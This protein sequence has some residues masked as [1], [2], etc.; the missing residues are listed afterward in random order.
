VGTTV[1]LGDGWQITVLSVIPDA[2]N[3]VLKEMSLINHRRLVT[4]SLLPE[5]E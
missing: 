5:S 2:T 1:N 4:N 3:I